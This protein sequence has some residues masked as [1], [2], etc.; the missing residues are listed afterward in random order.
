MDDHCN[1]IHCA[2]TA[3]A[4]VAGNT[5]SRVCTR[6]WHPQFHAM[7]DGLLAGPGKFDN[8]KEDFDHQIKEV[9]AKVLEIQK[10]GNG[11]ATQCDFS[12]LC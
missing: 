7:R 5:V 4:G 3:V 6:I 8:L 1:R 9:K 12:P 2:V 11:S 10:L